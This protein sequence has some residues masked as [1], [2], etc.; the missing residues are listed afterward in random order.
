MALPPESEDDE[1]GNQPDASA[2][3]GD[4][5]SNGPV[6]SSKDG[7]A[8]ASSPP[9]LANSVDLSFLKRPPGAVTN[10]V[11]VAPHHCV[12]PPPAL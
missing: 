11:I 8:A 3:Q 10:A 5:V 7:V 9:A 1:D 2:E 12:F 6:A 4:R